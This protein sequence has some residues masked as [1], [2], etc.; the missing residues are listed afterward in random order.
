M[1]SLAMTDLQSVYGEIS[2][3]D[4]EQLSTPVE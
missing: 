3:N 4:M 2:P 1:T